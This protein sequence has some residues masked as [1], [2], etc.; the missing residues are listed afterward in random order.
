VSKTKSLVTFR[1]I[2]GEEYVKALEFFHSIGAT[3]V[4]QV[5]WLNFFKCVEKDGSTSY[6]PV[7]MI[8]PNNLSILLRPTDIYSIEDLIGKEK[9]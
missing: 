7:G 1:S 4:Q 2:I 3:H 9:K 6:D 8:I 5:L